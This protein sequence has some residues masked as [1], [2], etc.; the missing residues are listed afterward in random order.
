MG[1]IELIEDYTVIVEILNDPEMLERISEDGQEVSFDD[2]IA[3]Q[4]ADNGYLLGWYVDGDLK[5]F[6]WVH[7]FTYSVMQIHAHFPAKNRLFAKHSGQAMLKWLQ[8]N[9]PAN[10]KRFIAMIPECYGDVIGFSL[11]EG[12]ERAGTMEKCAYRKG[13]CYNVEILGVNREDI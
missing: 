6:Y 10:V 3:K 4:M 9:I 1:S 8:N 13:R 5:G 7:A 11:R 12:L 2:G